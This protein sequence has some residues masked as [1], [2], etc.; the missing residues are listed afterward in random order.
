MLSVFGYDDAPHGHGHI[1]LKDV[2]VPAPNIVLGQG[3]GFEIVQ[4]RL[5]PGRLHHAMRTI[6]AAESALEW[7]IVRVNDQ[8]KQTFGQQLSSH[9][10]IR[11]WVA[12]S[13]IEI[14]AARM[15]VLNAAIKIDQKGSKA[16]LREIGIAKVCVPRAALKVIDYAVQ[17]WG[18]AGVCQDT[19]LPRLW[20]S[21]RTMRIV[22]GPDEVHLQQMGRREI[23]RRGEALGEKLRLQL[24]KSNEMMLSFRGLSTS[25]YSTKSPAKNKL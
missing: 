20:A 3:R 24:L 15:T 6:G 2:R 22:D 21:T 11:E 16:A 13:R 25:G 17:A 12:N 19:P 14:D 1:T 9:G 5:G 10:V 23:E 18:A 4:G 7:M 8:K